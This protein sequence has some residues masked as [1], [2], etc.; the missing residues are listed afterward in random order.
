[1]A[2]KIPCLDFY[3]HTF[4]YGESVMTAEYRPV[5]YGKDY[6][7]VN[8]PDKFQLYIDGKEIK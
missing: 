3:S 5:E 6:A 7:V 2:A 8:N 4:E 1:M